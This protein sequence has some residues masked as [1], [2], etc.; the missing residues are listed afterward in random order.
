MQFL[1]MGNNGKLLCLKGLSRSN[2][3]REGILR[4]NWYFSVVK[5]FAARNKFPQAKVARNTKKVGQA[6]FRLR[7]GNISGLGAQIG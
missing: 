5:T 4:L 6:C 3:R 7:V 2:I 1:F